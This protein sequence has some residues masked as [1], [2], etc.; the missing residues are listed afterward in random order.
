M[1]ATGVYEDRVVESGGAWLFAGKT[2]VLDSDRVDTLLAL[3]L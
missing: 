2:V 1:F 3:P